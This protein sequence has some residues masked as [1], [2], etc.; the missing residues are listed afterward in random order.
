MKQNSK[1]IGY[2]RAQ[3]SWEH[4]CVCMGFANVRLR[5]IEGFDINQAQTCKQLVLKAL[6]HAQL[7][8]LNR[9]RDHPEDW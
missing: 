9:F 3:E 5:K 7:H 4:V 1:F 2:V 6:A 8:F